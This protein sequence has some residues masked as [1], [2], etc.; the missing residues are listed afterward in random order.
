MGNPK[1]FVLLVLYTIFY[2]SCSPDNNDSVSPTIVDTVDNK[3]DNTNIPPKPLIIKK[4]KT[5]DLTNFKI[6]LNSA[7]SFYLGSVW[8]LGDTSKGFELTH[9]PDK[10]KSD[11]IYFLTNSFT[12]DLETHIPSYQSMF[13]YAKKFKPGSNN[14]SFSSETFFDYG[15]IQYYIVNSG[16]YKA[17][18]DLVAINDSTYIRK[19]NAIS[20]YAKLEYLDIYTDIQEIHTLYDQEYLQVNIP[21]HTTPPFHSKVHQ[22]F[23]SKVH[24]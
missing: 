19:K 1:Y 18:K 3:E 9:L 17:I 11:K 21:D 16:V 12:A 15:I 7:S 4:S 22:S 23:R 5:T 8:S 10:E 20:R 6:D 2:T 24:H 13:S 14:L